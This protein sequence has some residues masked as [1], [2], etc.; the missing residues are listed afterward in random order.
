MKLPSKN[1][2][3]RTILETLLERPATVYQ[4]IERH[5]LMT[6]TEGVIK[7]TYERLV[8]D[9]C[10]ERDGMVYR[11]TIK[12]RLKLAPPA[13]DEGEQDTV[14][15][16]YRADWHGPALSA[17]VAR[18]AGASFGFA[19]GSANTPREAPAVVRFGG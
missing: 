12:V 9:G 1:S 4:G 6:V 5:G 2:R 3:P 8:A 18:R 14:T 11:V 16:A 7:Q 17:S 19:R 13:A 15:P 10:L